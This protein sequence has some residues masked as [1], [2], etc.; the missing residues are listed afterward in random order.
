MK[1]ILQ[2]GNGIALVVTIIIDYLSNTVVF[3]D[4]TMA[5]VS[6]RYQNLFTP[7]GYAFS[8]WG[9]I[10]LGLLAFV[11]YQGRS[12]FNKG[13]EDEVV[14]QIGGWFILSCIA[15]C[16][17]VLAWLYDFIGLSVLIMILL[18]F[19]V[20]KI[21]QKTNMEMDD[22]PL[23]TIAFIWWPFCLYSGWISV[24]LIADVAAWLTKIKWNAWDLTPTTRAIVMIVVAG[25]IN[26][27]MTWN[28]N[29]REF[30][31]VGAW[32]L[33]AIAVSNWQNNSSVG[34]AAAIMAVILVLSSAI[35]AFKNR[36]FSP[37]DWQTRHPGKTPPK[38]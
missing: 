9:L 36:K 1:K 29:M 15:N 22:A 17:W 10:Y 16:C 26:L 19:S 24:A 30:A 21:V 18:L 28:R 38:F 23:R 37:W 2:I 8:I 14:E 5:T 35:H 4:N 20:W 6:A 12:L 31:L 32:A 33:V 27:F 3:N 13:A 34:W 25:L 11:I 7:A